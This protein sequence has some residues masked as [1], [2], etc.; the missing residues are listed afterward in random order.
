MSAQ[1]RFISFGPI[2]VPV[3]NHKDTLLLPLFPLE[4]FHNYTDRELVRPRWL[5]AVRS[6]EGMRT[7]HHPDSA[8]K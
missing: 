8:Q 1:S 7:R 6:E 2:A 5:A 3:G 4:Q